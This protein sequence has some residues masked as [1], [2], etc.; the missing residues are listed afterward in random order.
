MAHVGENVNCTCIV[1]VGVG[2]EQVAGLVSM[3]KETR[4]FKSCGCAANDDNEERTRS[5]GI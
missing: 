2:H 3:N 4:P 5:V 1:K